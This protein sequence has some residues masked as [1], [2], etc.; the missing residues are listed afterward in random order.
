MTD[1]EQIPIHSESWSQRELIHRILSRYVHV[2][3]DVGGF[4]PTFVVQERDDDDIH[5][6]LEQI[7]L[8]LAKLDWAVRLYPDEPWLMQVL[9][10]PTGQFPSKFV[11]FLM[12]MFAILST[13][14]AGEKWMESGRPDGGW[15]H[16]HSTIDAFIGYTLPIMVA[17]IAASFLQK[18]VAARYGVR[19]PHLFPL[20]GPAALW[21]PFGII[22]FT[23]MPRSDARYWPDRG[24]MGNT[25]ISAPLLLVASGMALALLGLKLTP[26][27]V[28]LSSAPLGLELP[29]LINII[30]FGMDGEILM[31]LKTA[32]AHPFTR[33]GSTLMFIGWISLLP[34]PTFP[35]GRVIIAR[36]GIVEARSGSTQIMLMIVVMLFAF[37]FGTFSS[38]TIWAPVVIILFILL[39]QRGSDPRLPVVLDD[40][41]GL[42]DAD[43]RRICMMLFLAFMFALPAQIP[44]ATHDNWD[45]DLEFSID[46][47]NVEIKDGWAN[48][49]VEVSNPSLIAQ[50]W[51]FS[52][53]E[54]PGMDFEWDD[55]V[56]D[57][58][59]AP[60]A[61]ICTGTVQPYTDK[62]FPISFK[63]LTNET[64]SRRDVTFR[65]NDLDFGYTISPQLDVFPHMDWRQSG[66]NAE[67]L[68][69][70]EI[71]WDKSIE[72]NVTLNRT[73]PVHSLFVLDGT[74]SEVL[75]LEGDETQI[76][77]EGKAGVSVESIDGMN[78]TIGENEFSMTLGHLQ[79]S[80]L[81][82][83]EEG[84]IIEP[85]SSVAGW[86]H[87]GSGGELR[88]NHEGSCE[89]EHTSSVLL[90][91]I[92][93]EWIWDLSLKPLA[94]IPEVVEGP[95]TIKAPFD[96]TITW[97]P[98]GQFS[99]EPQFVYI[100]TEGPQLEVVSTDDND[101]N[102]WADSVE[103]VND[104]LSIYN[105]GPLNLTVLV[106]QHGNGDDWN[107]SND[108]I[109]LAGETTVITAI[110]PSTGH[111][112]A[113]LENNDGIVELHLA[114]HEV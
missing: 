88:L 91:P 30:G 33:A 69:C 86:G 93:G 34:I 114:T 65:I 97:C 103:F 94:T 43:H 64:T 61:I 60:A 84:L 45:D 80:I 41:K 6:V 10:L 21:W 95:L 5:E 99:S 51:T 66:T 83:P 101:S 3:S 113:W 38:W 98:K 57:C 55:S 108:F 53:L 29:L 17:I 70:V 46:S 107:V 7:N 109:L 40:M 35:G 16:S 1:E 49:T 87:W 75:S 32:W 12:W 11:P 28:P 22:G 89:A 4:W 52:I 111:S 112:F 15:F 106:D 31:L 36:M 54:G 82:L 26:E 19:V 2:L 73:L 63:F 92:D 37:L 50:D 104:E 23:S 39:L 58:I 8:H 59:D 79:P 18:H 105:P 27:I 72:T 90:K 67:P 74:P 96:S 81:Y 44:F 24:S 13:I 20:F 42:N 76:C 78:I 85:N 68:A 56:L 100:V 102:V 77:V 110:A 47:K 25:A 14:Y 48:Q 9:P 71:V 62:K